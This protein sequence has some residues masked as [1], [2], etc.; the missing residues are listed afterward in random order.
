MGRLAY[1]Y[2]PVFLDHKP[3]AFHP[4]RPARLEAVQTYLTEKGF[5]NRVRVTPP[6][7]A[8]REQLYQ[9]HAPA[10]V[11][12]ILSLAGKEHVVLDIGDTVMSMH[13]V[14][15]A[16]HAAGAAVTA[17]DLIFSE[18]TADSVFI[19]VRPPGHHAEYDHAM[20]FCIFNNLAV[21]VGYALSKGYAKNVLIID[22][23][24]HHGNGTQHIFYNDP[25]VVYLSTHQYPFFPGTGR[26]EEHGGE[27]AHGHTINHPV[28][29]G[30]TD[31]DIIELMEQSLE[32]IESF[33]K[34]DLVFV[35]A[36]FDG[37]HSDPIG[38][39][40]MTEKGFYK[41][42]ELVVRFAQKHC[43]GRIVSV[44]EGGYDL[45]SLAKCVYQHVMCLLK[46]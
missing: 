46:H 25:R 43:N 29:F 17:V 19:A 15:A 33:F 7:P 42:T 8:T 26:S 28:S 32:E 41:L 31:T 21:G 12:R 36:G 35:S 45:D 2:D 30:Q 4:E 20:G 23:D 10:Y 14:E 11:D 13:S 22:W 40:Q 34:P 39:M 38:S 3:G 5:F 6:R 37:H 16:V 27:D 9:V 44:L 1:I 24:L 18:E